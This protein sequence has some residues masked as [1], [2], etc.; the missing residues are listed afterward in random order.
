MRRFGLT[1]FLRNLTSPAAATTTTA[2]STTT[3]NSKINFDST[4][5][6]STSQIPKL[7]SSCRL[8]STSSS[9]QDFYEVLGVSKG[10]SE[11]DIKKAY[12]KKAMETHPDRPNGNK[13]MFAKVGEAY[14]VLSDPQ[15][16]QVYDQ[17]GAEAATGAGGMGGMGGMGGFGG[18]SA[19]DIFADFFRSAGGGNPFAGGDGMG[20]Q[21]RRMRVSDIDTVVTCTLEE[22]YTGVTKTIRVNRPNIYTNCKGSGSKKGADGK[23]KCVNCN[24]SG[25]EVQQIRMG[26]GMVQQLVQECRR[27][28]GTGKTISPEDACGSCRSEGY[29]MKSEELSIH[30]P[31]GIPDGA[32][33][34]MRGMAGE[35][36]DAEPGD[37]N[38]QI[39][40]RPHAQFK[41]LGK[42]L[43]VNHTITLS[44]ALLGMELRLTMPDGRTVVATSPANQVLKSNTVL[45]FPGLGMPGNRESGSTANGNLYINV[46]VKM[47]ATLTNDQKTKLE[48]ILG[49][50]NRDKG[51]P[52]N[53]RVAG[54]M[55][56][57]S[58]EE[59]SRAK[60]GE[61]E[62]YGAGAGGGR[63]G[64]GGARRGG[65]GGQQAECVQQ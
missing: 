3:T 14:E 2:A 58:W 37:I 29:S 17:Y 39:Q 32:T 26:P 61:W 60:A 43:V 65:G 21:Q 49:A 24:G 34:V 23:K 15:K 20:G 9:K 30:I 50:P 44:E 64:G 57:Q 12:R 62:N 52:E 35:I 51:A 25:R 42:D 16:R 59:L 11:A 36:P 41:R 40:M 13:E 10:A 22:L 63:R 53:S 31:A 6:S 1:N 4:S 45:S 19:E 7:S 55:L 56:T 28:N 38:I 27:C 54:K 33:M 48:E 8:S 47:P 46:S 5:S 18:R